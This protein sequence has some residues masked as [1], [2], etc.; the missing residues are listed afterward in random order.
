MVNL[1]FYDLGDSLVHWTHSF[2]YFYHTPF[3]SIL[4]DGMIYKKIRKKLGKLRMEKSFGTWY[5]YSVGC[6]KR[7]CFL[8][9]FFYEMTTWKRR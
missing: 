7:N 1:A 9:F 6:V 3:F 4:Q 5:D 2:L 8:Q